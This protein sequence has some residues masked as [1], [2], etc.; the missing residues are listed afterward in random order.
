M[1]IIHNIYS[2]SHSS[3]GL[4][5]VALNLCREQN[6]LG[7]D[8][9]I[10]CLN[11]ENEL[12][13]ATSSSGLPTNKIRS[14]PVTGPKKFSLSIE[15]E[16]IAACESENIS[17][18]HQ[19]AL[20][21]G[22]SRITT[23]LRERYGIP[24]V[25]APH[26]CLEKWAVRKSWW[27]KRIA[28]ALYEGGNLRSASCLHACSEQ[29]IAGFRDFGLKN[30]IAVI[31]NGI[32]NSWLESIGDKDAF[33]KQYN[34]QSD[35]RVMLYLSRITPVKG[36]PMLMEALSKIRYKLNDWFIVIA[37]SDEFGH[38]AE[39]LEKI[40]QFKLEDHIRFTGLL[41][42]Q[43]KRNAFSI[44]DLFIL[45]SKREA[46]PVTVLE[47]LGAAVPVVTTKGVP[48]IELEQYGC[49][50]W[51]DIS[52]EAIA[53]AIDE[54]ISRPTDDLQRMGRKGK[55]LVTSKYTWTKSAEMTLELYTW[56]LGHRQKPDFIV[57]D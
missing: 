18:I 51:V 37:G 52:A 30:P 48:W 34:I 11:N 57:F 23:L 36:L 46:G 53:D 42:G 16:R 5:S 2:V 41:S 24:S 56:L 14:F 45:P 20:W 35:R 43:N 29:E 10:W 17:V 38:K 31:P 49:G 19:H 33:R 25:I 39:V 9:K 13:W 4:G 40:K 47:A 7:M 15:M 28:L 12:Q 1:N 26:G 22:L 8:S 50:W 54:A 6:S 32:G 21:K 3:F 44:A 27:K 55:E